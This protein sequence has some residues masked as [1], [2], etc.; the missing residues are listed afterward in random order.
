MRVLAFTVR[1]VMPVAALCA[2]VACQ[3]HLP[4]AP[5][6]LSDGIVIF[7]DRNYSGDSAHITSD[8]KNL[9]DFHGPCGKNAGQYS[10]TYSWT[11]CI[12]SVRV[13]PGWYAQLYEDDS[14][15]GDIL[16]VTSDVPDLRFSSGPCHEGFNDCVSSIRVFK[17]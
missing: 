1:H 13:A 9:E 16:T 6:E 10:N 12:S 5:S 3:K 8:V 15:R 17:Q 7:E 14:F 4:M 2:L 11:D